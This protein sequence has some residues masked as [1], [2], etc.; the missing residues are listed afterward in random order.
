MQRAIGIHASIASSNVTAGRGPIIA[1]P[2]R[3]APS[4]MRDSYVDTLTS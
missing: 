2:E 3:P 4:S 1:L